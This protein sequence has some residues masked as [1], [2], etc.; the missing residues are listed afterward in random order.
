[1]SRRQINT[2]TLAVAYLH[3]GREE[4][5]PGYDLIVPASEVDQTI[6]QYKEL[7]DLKREKCDAINR[8]KDSLLRVI[9]LPGGIRV[10]ADPTSL[11]YFAV[12]TTRWIDA[13]N[14]EITF[15]LEEFRSFKQE[16]FA[17]VE[18]IV[19]ASRSHKDTLIGLTDRQQ[20]IDYP[21][22]FTV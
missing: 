4:P 9:T 22:E 6:A 10:Q 18:K 15:T 13:D 2:T 17:E 11:S 3:P 12:E 16:V 8:Y 20:I 5:G 21:V 19:F 1:M 14:S 7:S